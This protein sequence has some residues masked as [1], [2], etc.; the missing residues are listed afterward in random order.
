MKV[1]P[2]S[3][4]EIMNFIQK[5]YEEKI[6]RIIQVEKQDLDLINHLSGIK[7]TYL[8][9][10]FRTN[11]SL[12]EVRKKLQFVVRKNKYQ[13]KNKSFL[14]GRGI[15]ELNS[16]NMKKNRN[17]I[18]NYESTEAVILSQI[19]DIRE[20]DINYLVRVAIDKNLR[21]GKWYN[22]VCQNGFV[23]S[24]ENEP[25]ILEMPELGILAF[26]IETTKQPLNSLILKLM[27]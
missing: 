15:G 1:K 24:I 22:I 10:F 12:L 19:E 25:S 16:F 3:E 2:G 7:G 11:K 18:N 17:R 4:I 20:H 8:K 5:K 6:M 9:I 13:K 27:K 21:A 26:D 23:V 14:S